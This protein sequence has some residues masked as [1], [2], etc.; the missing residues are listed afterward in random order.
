MPCYAMPPARW[1]S[2]PSRQRIG[3]FIRLLTYSTLMLY[4]L[5]PRAVAHLLYLPFALATALL[6]FTRPRRQG[7]L[8]A[9]IYLANMAQIALELLAGFGPHSLFTSWLATAAV[10]VTLGLLVLDRRASVAH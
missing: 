4:E 9:T 8:P 5:S 3:T 2:R 6:L 7:P 10:A 1:P